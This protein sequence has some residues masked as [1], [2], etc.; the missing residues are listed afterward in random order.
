MDTLKWGGSILEVELR[1]ASQKHVEKTQSNFPV[2]ICTAGKSDEAQREAG[3]RLKGQ[4][5]TFFISVQREV[6]KC[7]SPEEFWI[8]GRT[9]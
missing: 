6:T 4:E 2:S 8:L 5:V 3:T 7:H 9:L 1:V